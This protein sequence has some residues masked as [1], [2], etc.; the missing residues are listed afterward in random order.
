MRIS[1]RIRHL[2]HEHGWS[3]SELAR[4]AS[5]PQTTISGIE[6]D[7]HFPTLKHLFQLSSAFGISLSELLR[8]V[9]DF[10]RKG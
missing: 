3:Q 4:K 10:E 8:D 5:V 6:R 1:E 9:D 2:R 7:K